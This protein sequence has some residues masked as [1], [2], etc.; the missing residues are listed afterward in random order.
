GLCGAVLFLISDGLL[1][2]NRF[3]RPF[4]VAQAVILTTYFTAQ[5]LIA[6]SV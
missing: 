2:I 6:L 3:M 5:W 4:R 1:A